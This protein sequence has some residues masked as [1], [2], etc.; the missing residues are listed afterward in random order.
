[1]GKSLI[2]LIGLLSMWVWVPTVQAQLPENF[3]IDQVSDNWFSVTGIQF[4]EEGHLWGWSKFGQVLLAKEDYTQPQVVLDISEEVTTYG[5]LGLIGFTLHPNF[6]DNGHIYLLYMV[7]PHHFYHFG[8]TSYDPNKS[9]THQATIG[10]LTRYTVD[11]STD[12]WTVDPASRKVLMGAQGE[13]PGQTFA[14]LFDSHGV[15]SLVFGAD[16]SLLVSCGDGASYK[17]IDAGAYGEETGS[18]R[19][20][21]LE[22][23]IIRPDQDIGTFK[24]QYLHSP[25]GKVLRI[26]PDTG[27]GIPLQS[28]LRSKRPLRYHLP[29]LGPGFSA[30]LSLCPATGNR[31]SR[32]SKG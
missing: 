30:T 4:D 22:A 26:N 8:T 5:D 24:S 16:G 29:R 17:G 32:S 10:R 19:E 25:N 1:M 11:L 21:A 23:G 7:D 20:Q 15:G 31:K 18:F 12:T 13:P 6:S 2:S 3:S 14:M 27:A 28:L 9:E